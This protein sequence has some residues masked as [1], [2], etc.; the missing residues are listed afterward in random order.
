[1]SGGA[2]ANVRALAFYFGYIVVTILWGS[3]SVLVAWIFPY[4]FRFHFVIGCWTRMVLIWLRVCCG[5]LTG[6]AA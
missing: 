3:L 5:V 1:M 6:I 4:R 2:I